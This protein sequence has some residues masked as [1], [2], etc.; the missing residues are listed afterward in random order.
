MIIEVKVLLNW[1]INQILWDLTVIDDSIETVIYHCYGV[2]V[3]MNH[4]S[5]VGKNIF[6]E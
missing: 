3:K 4:F 1:G 2:C 5:F 6:L